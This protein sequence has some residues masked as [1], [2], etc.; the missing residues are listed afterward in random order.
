MW[1]RNALF[2]K[3][4]NLPTGS[5]DN[6]LADPANQPRIIGNSNEVRRNESATDWVLPSQKSFKAELIARRDVHN[7]LVFQEKL[8]L[9]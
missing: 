8:I 9:I 5:F 3:F 2:C 4:R 6:P 7:G 1:Q